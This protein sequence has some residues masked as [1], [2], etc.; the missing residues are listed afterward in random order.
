MKFIHNPKPTHKQKRVKT[1]FAFLPIRIDNE[2]RWMEKCKIEQIYISVK[3]P[4]A[5]FSYWHNLKFLNN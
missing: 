4:R 2:T 5:Y 3:S 1:R